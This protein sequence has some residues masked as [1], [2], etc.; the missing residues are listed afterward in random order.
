MSRDS[1]REPPEAGSLAFTF[2]ALV[3]VFTGIGYALDRFLH[4]LPWLMVAGV[5]VGAGLGFVY[6]VYILFTTGSGGRGGKR[7][8]E[9]RRVDDDEDRDER[10]WW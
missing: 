7:K 4:T 2:V 8:I 6:L 9:K 3:L 10:S 1:Q 5:F